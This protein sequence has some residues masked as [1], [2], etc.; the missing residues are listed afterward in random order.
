MIVSDKNVTDALA[1]LADDPH[2]L[3]LARKDLTDCENQSKQIYAEAF[4]KTEGTEKERECA[5][6]INPAYKAAKKVEGMAI[7][8]LERHKSRSR[9]AEMLIEMWRSEQANVRAAE[10]IR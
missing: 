10:R 8:E 1:Y 9:A 2:P 7:L 5:T 3:A 4:L 6:E